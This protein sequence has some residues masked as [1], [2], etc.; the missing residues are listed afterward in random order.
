MKCSNCL[1]TFKTTGQLKLAAFDTIVSLVNPKKL[2]FFANEEFS[3]FFCRWACTFVTYR[4][5]S[6]IIK[7]PSLAAKIGK[8]R[9]KSFIGSATGVLGW[10]A[11]SCFR[12][13]L[14]LIC[15]INYSYFYKGIQY[16]NIIFFR[17]HTLKTEIGMRVSKSSAMNKLL[18][19][20]ALTIGVCCATDL[21]GIKFN[22]NL[23]KNSTE[24]DIVKIVPTPGALSVTFP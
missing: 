21:Y 9:K 11:T 6:L 4:E 16:L 2:F 12:V 23:D 20:L 1:G 18:L 15:K 5:N 3:R 19:Y 17:D 14:G 8:R 22:R 24:E 13:D 7:W 10:V